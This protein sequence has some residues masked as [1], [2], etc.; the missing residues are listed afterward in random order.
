M[1]M[2]GGSMGYGMDSYSQ[3]LPTPQ[4]YLQKAA[5]PTVQDQLL[6]MYQQQ[7]LSDQQ[8]E[9]DKKLKALL[10]YSKYFIGNR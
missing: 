5:D 1:D 7:T 3:Y 4:Q 6:T 10:H 2:G 9:K 8:K